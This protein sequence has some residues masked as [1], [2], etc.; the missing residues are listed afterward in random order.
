MA[1]RVAA[2]ALATSSAAFAL[3]SASR[4]R[5]MESGHHDTSPPLWVARPIPITLEEDAEH[6]PLRI[7]IDA[8]SAPVRDP[9]IQSSVPALLS[10]QTGL[11]FEGIGDGLVSTTGS[12]F[13][14][15]FSPPDPQGDVGPNH[16]V[17]IVNTSLAVFGKDGKLLFGPVSTQTLFAGFGGACELGIGYDCLVLYDPLADRWIMSKLAFLRSDVGPFLECIAVSSTADPTGQYHRYSFPYS[18]FNDYQKI[19]VW[20]DAYYATYNMYPSAASTSVLLTRQI[21]AFDRARMLQGQP[22]SSQC[23]DVIATQ[24]SGLVPADMDGFLPPP[25]GEPATIVGYYGNASLLFYR[26]HVDWVTPKNSSIDS[27]VVAGAPF[28]Q[29]CSGGRFGSCVP[30]Q[31]GPVLDGLG[32]RM[33]YRAAYR[34]MGPYESLVVNHSVA[35]DTSGG[36]RWYEIRDPAGDP[37]VFQQSTYAPDSNWRWMG[38]AAMDGAGSIGLG[39]NVSGPNQHVGIGI[40]GRIASDP[41]GVMGQ[42]ESIVFSG[43][44]AQANTLRWGDYSS[45]SV[46]PSDECTFWYT[47]EY[48]PFDGASNWRTRILTFQLPGCSTSPDFAVWISSAQDSTIQGG[49]ATYTISTAPLRATAAARQI[50]LTISGLG[51][52]LTPSLTS[53]LVTAGQAATLTVSADATAPIGMVPFTIQATSGSVVQTAVSSI[54]V[55][56][57]DFSI[58]LDKDTVFLGA[59]ATADVLVRVPRAFGDSQ[60][61]VFSSSGLPPAVSASFDPASS[62]VDGGSTLHLSS[63]PFL[64]PGV[65]ALRITASGPLNSHSAVLHLRALSQPVATILFPV[66]HTTLSGTAQVSLSGA[67]SVGTTLKQLELFVDGVKIPGAI[68]EVSPATVGWNTQQVRDGPHLLSALATDAQGFHGTSADVPIW[69]ENSNICGCSSDAGGWE[70]LGLA[71]LLAAI[72]RRTRR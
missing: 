37:F 52:G 5:L 6:E 19:G 7:Q 53:P 31:G 34:N 11:N 38:S 21:C 57:K 1:L 33:M 62:P 43:G 25:A 14:V 36:V 13:A 35:T 54:A 72:R 12:P 64:S 45:L 16:Y 67:A 24:L 44:G 23:G 18:N 22:A 42:G 58:V 68:T 60:V 63:G 61:V 69:V 49:S 26:F 56:D 28:H 29:L 9:V 17:Q 48:I 55:I 3:P 2:L 65:S 4:P 59:A 40:A 41:P 30:Q 66:S 8:P 39:F 51:P 70:M 32:D 27:V 10:L 46:D 71:G 50:Q 47:A 15:P 20:P